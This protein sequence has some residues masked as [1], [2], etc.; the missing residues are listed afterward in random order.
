[1]S[2]L[3]MTEPDVWDK[4]MAYVAENSE[5]A[6]LEAEIEQEKS[7]KDAND[8]FQFSSIESQRLNCIYDDEPLGF[9]KDPMGSA[10]KIKAQDPLEEVDICD[11]SVKIPT[12]ISTK[13]DKDF[14]VQIIELVEEIQRLFRLGLQR[15]A[16][17]ESRCG[18][19]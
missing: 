5:K 8:D 13:I 7:I 16:K 4:I 1:M 19:T 14:K 11:G 17:F 15:V 10:E 9:E 3:M 18:R 6:A 12:Y 2:A